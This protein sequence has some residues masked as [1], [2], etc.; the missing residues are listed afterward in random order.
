MKLML[1][2][3]SL[4]TLLCGR[5]CTCSG[6]FGVSVAMKNFFLPVT[7]FK[8]LI[9]ISHNLFISKKSWKVIK[10]CCNAHDRKYCVR[11]NS[12]SYSFCIFK[13]SF[14]QKSLLETTFHSRHLRTWTKAL[15]SRRGKELQRTFKMQGRKGFLGALLANILFFK[16]T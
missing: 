5:C 11:N 14:K 1:W 15:R 7:T 13:L 12:A 16:F 10:I 8:A 4:L 9:F 3:W 6:D 2:W